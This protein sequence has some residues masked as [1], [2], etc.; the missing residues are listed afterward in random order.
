MELMLAAAFVDGEDIVVDAG[1]RET[2]MLGRRWTSLKMFGCFDAKEVIP[3]IGGVGRFLAMKML[4]S[5]TLCVS[6]LSR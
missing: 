1:V 3:E 5:M 2:T 6:V 4:L